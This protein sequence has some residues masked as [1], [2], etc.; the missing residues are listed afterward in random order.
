MGWIIVKI[1]LIDK[2]LTMIWDFLKKRH[3]A[4][5]VLMA[6]RNFQKK[7][8]VTLNV[9]YFIHLKCMV[10]YFF[11]MYE[12]LNQFFGLKNKEAR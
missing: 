7:F 10:H 11:L 1:E 3:L 5:L 12:Y 2:T 4:S 9:A 8:H 6:I